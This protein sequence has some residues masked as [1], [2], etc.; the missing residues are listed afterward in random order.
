LVS[1][2]ATAGE[3]TPPQQVVRSATRLPLVERPSPAALTLLSE[4]SEL[5]ALKKVPSVCWTFRFLG[6]GFDMIPC[7]CASQQPYIQLLSINNITTNQPKQRTH[8]HALDR[9]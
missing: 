5:L 8:H 9:R 2:F 4:R 3:S 6:R 1:D 7:V